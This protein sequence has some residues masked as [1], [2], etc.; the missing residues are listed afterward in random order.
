MHPAYS[1]KLKPSDYCLFVSMAIDSLV[2]ASF[3]LYIMITGC[4]SS[5]SLGMSDDSMRVAL[6]KYI[7]LYY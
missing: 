2:K 4:V 1:S 5:L 6:L 7:R 3:Q